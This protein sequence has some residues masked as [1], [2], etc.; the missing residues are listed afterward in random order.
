MKYTTQ[1]KRIYKP[2]PNSS[3]THLFIQPKNILIFY[4]QEIIAFDLN[5]SFYQIDL[6]RGHMKGR[7]SS[8]GLQQMSEHVDNRDVHDSLELAEEHVG[9]HGP[10]DGSEVAAH[11]ETMVYSLKKKRWL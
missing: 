5:V 10:E 7:Y 8:Q 2:N 3:A 9:Q 4:I 1:P 6:H 11:R